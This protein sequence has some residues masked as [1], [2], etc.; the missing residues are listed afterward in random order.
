MGGLRFNPQHHPTKEC[1]TDV[2]C[3]TALEAGKSDLKELWPGKGLRKSLSTA[4]TEQG[5][6]KK[7]KEEQ[8]AAYR[9]GDVQEA[10]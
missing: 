5:C 4:S 10:K 3:L 8:G 2:F 9:I 6:H 1:R 7:K